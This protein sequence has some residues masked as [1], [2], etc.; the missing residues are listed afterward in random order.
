MTSRH[1]VFKLVASHAACP[2]SIALFCIAALLSGQQPNRQGALP[3]ARDP[4]SV[5]IA[6]SKLQKGDFGLVDVEIV[7]KAKAVQ[8]IPA[9]ESQFDRSTDQATKEKIANALV[10]LGDDQDGRYWSFLVDRVQN[11][12]K[13]DAPSPIAYGP[14]GSALREPSPQFVTWA[15]DHNLDVPT[16]LRNALFGVPSAIANIA[17]TD[18]RRS[19]PLLRQALRSPNHMVATVAALGLAELGDSDSVPL[20]I[21]ASKRAP[22]DA[23]V[24]IAKALVYFDS[25]AAQQGFDTLVPRDIAR[26]L[27]DERSQGKRPF[28]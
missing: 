8:A 26:G 16:A 17:T 28:N 23:S 22:R 5:P 13:S 20:I 9:L 27:R 7:A 1:R 12:L 18:D 2:L 21:D 6:I 3:Y 15:K 19:I 24:A 4:A 14:D 10:R 11:A 25:P